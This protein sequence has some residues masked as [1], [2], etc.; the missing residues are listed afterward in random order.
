MERVDLTIL[1]ATEG[2]IAPL[3]ALKTLDTVRFAD[4]AFSIRAYRD[5]R[6]LIGTTGIGKVNAAAIT[7]AALSNFT[8]GEVC[9]VGCAG[10]Y[11]GSGL[12]IADVLIADACLVADEGI[13]TKEGPAPLSEMGIPLVYKNGRA[14]CDCFPLADHIRRKDIRAIL[15]EGVYGTGPSGALL[16][17]AHGFELRYGPSLTVAMTSGDAQTASD[18]FHRFGALAENMEGSAIA[19]TCLLFDVPFLE[20]RGISNMAGDREKARWDL[21][22]ACDHCIAVVMR[23][24]DNRTKQSFR[25]PR[26]GGKN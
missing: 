13:L 3:A 23:L 25:L 22:A 2:E 16:L 17:G 24:L 1:G 14:F 9:N 7:A 15:P 26:D 6:L 8:S 5:L 4:C 19:Q 11:S 20:I 10:A 12:S 18:R 21:P